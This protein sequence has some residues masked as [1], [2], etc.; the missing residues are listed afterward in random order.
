MASN[1]GSQEYGIPPTEVGLLISSTV[2]YIRLAEL[3]LQLP[4]C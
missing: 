4:T 3:N 1:P 2:Y